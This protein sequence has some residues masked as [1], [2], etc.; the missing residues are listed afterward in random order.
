MCAILKLPYQYFTDIKE[1]AIQ[2]PTTM[3]DK[4][5]LDI[6]PSLDSLNDDLLVKIPGFD[7][8]LPAVE[9]ETLNMNEIAI[10]HCL[11]NVMVQFDITV[12][13][14]SDT[15]LVNVK[16][17]SSCMV[18]VSETDSHTK[19]FKCKTTIVNAVLPAELCSVLPKIMRKFYDS[20][21]N[22]TIPLM[23]H[24]A[25][26][27]LSTISEDTLVSSKVSVPTSSLPNFISP[28]LTNLLRGTFSGCLTKPVSTDALIDRTISF[29]TYKLC[30]E[31]IYKVSKLLFENVQPMFTCNVDPYKMSMSTI[32]LGPS[33]NDRHLFEIAP[34][35]TCTALQLYKAND[36]FMEPLGN[37]NLTEVVRRVL[38]I[39][40]T[41][42]SFNTP[43]YFNQ[44]EQHHD[45]L[46]TVNLEL[47]NNK[48]ISKKMCITI[49]K[50][51]VD[52]IFTAFTKRRGKVIETN[53]APPLKAI[54]YPNDCRNKVV[55]KNLNHQVSGG[56]KIRRKGFVRLYK[57]CKSTS[58]IPAEKLSTALSK[59]ANLDDFFQA[60]GSGK[61]LSSV[62]EGIAGQ[63]ILTSIFQ[64]SNNF[65][66]LTDIKFELYL[67]TTSFP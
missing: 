42:I 47:L 41:N 27:Q 31:I 46:V 7:E 58:N 30:S 33:C 49:S 18:P 56:S 57:K 8:V 39:H 51:R 53:E 38:S 66:L 59:I 21:M 60:L 12:P 2:T 15:L 6:G 52:S 63:K 37:F 24:S 36:N 67:P 16:K 50:L 64:V 43:S 4:N 29:K 23:P 3:R 11:T 19:I 20:K 65:N 35:N 28:L 55:K 25:E 14:E 62:F 13:K 1:M 32:I 34:K 54:E 9:I 45:D 5:L 26:S 22:V 44:C 10:K 48:D 40:I 61:L 17:S